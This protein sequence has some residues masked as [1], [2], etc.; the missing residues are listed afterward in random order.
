MPMFDD[1]ASRKEGLTFFNFGISIFTPSMVNRLNQ[2]IVICPCVLG[3]SEQVNYF[4]CNIQR[5]A[6]SAAAA[7][8]APVALAPVKKET[9]KNSK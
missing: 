5:E 4:D 9:K 2:N 8:A 1:N 7:T 6:E 3:L